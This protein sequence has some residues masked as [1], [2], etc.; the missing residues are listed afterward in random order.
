MDPELD[1]LTAFE[2]TAEQVRARAHDVEADRQRGVA[3]SGLGPDPFRP[4]DAPALAAEAARRLAALQLWRASSSG[5]VTA[6]LARTQHA[7]QAVHAAAE[8]ARAALSRDPHSH[9]QLEVLRA[10]V[11]ALQVAT[12]EAMDAAVPAA[13]SGGA[14][15]T[16]TVSSNPST[17]SPRRSAS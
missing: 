2:Q 5:R 17:T 4:R 10:Q 1:R 13:L 7:A 8:A 16:N 11:L 9:P 6:A 3:W 12:R 14:C 15:A